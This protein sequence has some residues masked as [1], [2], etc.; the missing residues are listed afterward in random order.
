MTKM[1]LNEYPIEVEDLQIDQDQQ[2][3]A[4]IIR[5]TF[6]VTHADYHDVTTLLYK[7]DFLVDIPAQGIKMRAIIQ[8][9]ST[10]IDDLYKE[11]ATGKFYLELIEQTA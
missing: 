2:K 4:T 8:N 7:N 11:G 10:S 3:N 1:F 9:Y 5:A 6:Q